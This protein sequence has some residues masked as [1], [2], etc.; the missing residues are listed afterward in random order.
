M[1]SS[2][3]RVVTKL[4]LKKPTKPQLRAPTKTKMSAKEFI[5]F[6]V[7]TPF[8]R[9]ILTNYIIPPPVVEFL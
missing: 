9:E 7:V 3:N 8:H 5:D 4:K 6:N 2:P 1:P